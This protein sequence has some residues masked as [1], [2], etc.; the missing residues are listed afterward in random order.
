MKRL[1][2]GLLMA[3]VVPGT[4]LGHVDY[5]PVAIVTCQD[6]TGRLEWGGTNP[7]HQD[8]T[9]IL[10]LDGVPSGSLTLLAATDSQFYSG[11]LFTTYNK[12][13][14][15]AISVG[16]SFIL[17]EFI[18]APKCS[19]PKP[20]HHTPRPQI[21]LPPTATEAPAEP[22]DSGLVTLIVLGF[23]GL[24]TVATIIGRR[25]DVH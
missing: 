7:T 15:V 20:T 3:L 18:A 10:N 4:V 23:L 13:Q 17:D 12:S 8:V 1:A 25:T 19:Q 5:K 22:H 16:E 9:L 2:L 11:T 6:G 24:V 21:T 14:Q